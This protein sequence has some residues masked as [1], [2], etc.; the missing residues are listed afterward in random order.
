MP[1]SSLPHDQKNR[2]LSWMLYDMAFSK[3][4]KPPMFFACAGGRSA[5]HCL[6]AKRGKIDDAGCSV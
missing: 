3:P 5:R 6:G 2:D 4:D 1:L